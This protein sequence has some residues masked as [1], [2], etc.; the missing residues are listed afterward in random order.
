MGKTWYNK[1]RA[2]EFII[3]LG[4]EIWLSSLEHLLLLKRTQFWLPMFTCGPQLPTTLVPGDLAFSSV[5][6]DSRHT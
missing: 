4:L 6:Q 2:I 3:K 1:P 5:S